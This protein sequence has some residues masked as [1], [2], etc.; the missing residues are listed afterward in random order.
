M[1]QA[2]ESSYSYKN[3]FALGQPVVDRFTHLTLFFLEELRSDSTTNL[4][5][6]ISIYRYVPIQLAVIGVVLHMMNVACTH[7][8]M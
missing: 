5:D 7:Y 6:L 4:Q 1:L 8:M 2:G 3:D